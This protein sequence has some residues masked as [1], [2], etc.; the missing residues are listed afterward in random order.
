[1]LGHINDFDSCVFKCSSFLR[2]N[3]ASN[4]P[5]EILEYG[6]NDL[7]VFVFYTANFCALN[8]SNH[9]CISNQ[10]ITLNSIKSL[11]LKKAQYSG[12]IQDFCLAVFTGFVAIMRSLFFC[13]SVLVVFWS[14][15]ALCKSGMRSIA[16]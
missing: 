7:C 15:K 16:L 5:V 14:D 11:N 10:T 8:A 13:I 6:K 2:T 1:M 3:L 12:I 4:Y 9:P